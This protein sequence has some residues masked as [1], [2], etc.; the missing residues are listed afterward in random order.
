MNSRIKSECP[1]VVQLREEVKKISDLQLQDEVERLK[2]QLKTPPV[3]AR[4]SQGEWRK[5]GTR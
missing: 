2:E 4:A 5:M 1:A 3:K